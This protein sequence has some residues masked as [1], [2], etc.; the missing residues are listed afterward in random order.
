[1]PLSPLATFG[2]P[3]ATPGP[4]KHTGY[5]FLRSRPILT[6]KRPTPTFHD[7]S[8]RALNIEEVAYSLF[9]P[10][11]I[12]SSRGWWG[13]PK[14]HMQWLPEPVGETVAGYE[15]FLG[16]RGLGWIFQMLRLVVGRMKFPAYLNTPLE[17][18]TS[19]YPM[20][21]FSHGLA[22]TRTTYSQYCS[23]L[24]SEG[25]VVLAIEHR[26][27]SGP[28]VML[29]PEE[30]SKEPRALQY[31]R[32]SEL[33]WSDEED[34]TLTRFRT[35]QLDIRLREVYETYQSFRRLLSPA[36][37]ESMIINDMTESR[38]EEW[39]ASFRDEVDLE[40]LSLTGHSFGGS[41]VIDLLNSRPPE[42]FQP[43]PVKNVIALDPWLDP[44]PAPS[45]STR[46]EP[47]MPPMLIINSTGF[48]TWSEHF[49]R[50]KTIVDQAGGSLITILGS[51]HQSFSDFP[52][53]MPTSLNV[54]LGYLATTHELSS[55]FLRG[56]L[57][58]AR[59]LLGKKPDLGKYEKEKDGKMAGPTGDVVLHLLATAH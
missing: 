4:H 24:A 50:L 27:G 36:G 19:K 9:Y 40:S 45:V 12:P 58:S 20:I 8:K 39:I 23:A 2:F 30:G 17:H 13:G 49:D 42:G 25:Y 32:H 59:S 53:L 54:A 33:D 31:I 3:Q 26:D 14:A 38:M 46:G 10:A 48:T 57:G 34:S 22:G 41:T 43:L 35:L 47:H 15:R 21:I 1:M 29:P 28:S 5:A 44:L 16:R 11:H 7:T 6:Y 56:S 37:N 51:N 18:P 55:A 52:L